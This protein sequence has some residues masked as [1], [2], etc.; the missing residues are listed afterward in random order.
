[1]YAW[2]YR[3]LN[4]RFMS[5]FNS[6]LFGASM[7][8]TQDEEN[9][10]DC[11]FV[12]RQNVSHLELIRAGITHR[13]YSLA[14]LRNAILDRL[15]FL[16]YN[17]TGRFEC[18]RVLLLAR[19]DSYEYNRSYNFTYGAIKKTNKTKIRNVFSWRTHTHTHIPYIWLHISFPFRSLSI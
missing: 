1:M 15:L 7:I 13:L 18:V 12:S 4:I 14:L 10:L 6:G 5:R 3:F 2:T 9:Q 19:V 11:W 8:F 16:Q 17:C